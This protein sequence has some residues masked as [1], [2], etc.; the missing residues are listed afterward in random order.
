MGS[1]P[2]FLYTDNVPVDSE[3][4]HNSYFLKKGIEFNV[5]ASRQPVCFVQYSGASSPC[6]W[7]I[8]QGLNA[9]NK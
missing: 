7:H 9:Y 3:I 8:N 4:L 2:V 1:M 6:G 5:K